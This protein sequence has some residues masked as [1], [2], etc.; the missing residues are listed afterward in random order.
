MGFFPQGSASNKASDLERWT[1]IST[2]VYLS[3]A[4]AVVLLL[5]AVF[6]GNADDAIHSS[7]QA[8]ARPEERGH[9]WVTQ[10]NVQ[11]DKK[12]EQINNCSQH[13]N[14]GQLNSHP[15]H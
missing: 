5:T 1:V 13:S 3:Q 11:K 6:F 9:H 14:H 4:I 15:V 2:G 10:P 12:Y 8:R 7:H